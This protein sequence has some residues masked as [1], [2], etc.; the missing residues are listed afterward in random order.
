[1]HSSINMFSK[2]KMI[3]ICENKTSQTYRMNLI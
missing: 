3:L 1:M 2:P